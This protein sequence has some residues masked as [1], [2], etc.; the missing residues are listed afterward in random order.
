VDL[1]D[2][3]GFEPVVPMVIVLVVSIAAGSLLMIAV[4]LLLLAVFAG[5]ACRARAI[6]RKL[7]RARDRGN[8]E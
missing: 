4:S 3:L 8:P 1:L 2:N 7:A 6:E 5:L